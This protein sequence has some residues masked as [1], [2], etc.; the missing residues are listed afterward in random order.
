MM[1][2]HLNALAAREGEI[3]IVLVLSNIAEK[4]VAI[5]SIQSVGTI[6]AVLRRPILS[7]RDKSLSALLVEVMV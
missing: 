1:L 4:N 6:L 3:E 2:R 7:V 5:L